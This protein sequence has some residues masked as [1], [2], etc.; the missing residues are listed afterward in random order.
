[1]PPLPDDISISPGTD[2][3]RM[4]LMLADGQ[5]SAAQRAPLHANMPKFTMAFIDIYSSSMSFLEQ[6]I[7]MIFI[8]GFRRQ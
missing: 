8:F 1:M 5:R 2:I 7:L 4:A 6:I 3:S